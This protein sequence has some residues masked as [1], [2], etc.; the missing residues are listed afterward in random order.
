MGNEQSIVKADGQA[1]ESSCPLGYTA[2][3]VAKL[4]NAAGGGAEKKVQ[5]NGNKENGNNGKKRIYDVY[6]QEVDP[7]NM[8]PTSG[9]E[10]PSPGQKERLSVEREK[11]NIPK[12]GTEDTWTY[13]SPQQFYNS[14]KRKGKGGDVVEEDMDIVVQIHNQMNE[15]TW[16]E[17]MQWEKF[18]HCDCDDVKLARFQGKPDQ[19][20]PT[21]RL[22][23]WT[24]G[25]PP[26]DRHDWIVDRC[27]KEVRYVI[28]YYYT[29]PEVAKDNERINIH[30]RPALDSF[31]NAYDR[32]RM[33]FL[34][35]GAADGQE[36]DVPATESAL[37]RKQV[38]EGTMDNEEFNKLAS[39]TGAKVRQIADQVGQ[40]CGGLLEV[41]QSCKGEECEQVSVAAN[42]CAAKYI[43]PSQATDFMTSMTENTDAGKQY[44]QMSGCLE[45]FHL[46][47]RRVIA[48][49]KGMQQAGPEALPDLSAQGAASSMQQ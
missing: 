8:M 29:D 20:S 21:A 2:E 26:F 15:R 17:V 1:Q 33:R 38:P 35:S 9:N 6:S 40:N 28:D 14:L 13:P 22:R 11:S 30:V 24:G 18:N 10:I 41:M 46:M 36:K 39:L 47:A 12:G 34:Y 5:E 23:T 7:R 48:Y 37:L 27:G 3:D 19:L 31:I 43:C 32:M 49:E 16:R 45:R 4:K 42:F 44:E 25:E